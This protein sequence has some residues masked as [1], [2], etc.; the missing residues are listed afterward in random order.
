MEKIKKESVQTQFLGYSYSNG[1]PFILTPSMQIPSLQE[2]QISI[3]DSV[4][5]PTERIVNKHLSK[6]EEVWKALA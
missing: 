2:S 6:Y 1:T 3:T 5:C 4:P